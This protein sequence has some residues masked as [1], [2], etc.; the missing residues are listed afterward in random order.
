MAFRATANS[1]R[2]GLAKGSYKQANQD[3]MGFADALSAGLVRSDQAKM[4]EDM[5]IRREKRAEARRVKA[6]A[7]AA[8]K[9]QKKQATL[10][11]LFLGTQSDDVKN[12]PTAKSQVMTLI[13]EGGISSLSSLTDYMDKNATFT[14]PTTEMKP[15][16]AMETAPPFRIEGKLE[17]SGYT[18]LDAKR[19]AENYPNSVAGRTSKQMIDSGLNPQQVGEDLGEEEITVDTGFSFGPKITPIDTSKLREDNWYGTYQQLIQKGDTANALLVDEWAKSTGN[20]FVAAGI[21]AND[22][23]G[24][25]PT[26]ITQMSLNAGEEGK[27]ALEPYITAAEEAEAAGKVDFWTDLEAMANVKEPTLLL[28]LTKHPEGSEAHTVISAQILMNEAVKNSQNLGVAAQALDKDEAFYNTAIQ[29]YAALAAKSNIPEM[30]RKRNAENLI[31]LNVMSILSRDQRLNNEAVALQN[32]PMKQLSAKAFMVEGGFGFIDPNTGKIKMPTTAQI[33]KYEKD[34]KEAT[35]VAAKPD[36]FGQAESLAKLDLSVLQVMKNLGTLDDTQL[37]LIDSAIATKTGQETVEAN[38]DALNF[39]GIK[40]TDGLNLKVANA[41]WNAFKNPDG[42][43]NQDAVNK[44]SR[45]RATIEGIESRPEEADKFTTAYAAAF[46]DFISRP[47]TEALSGEDLVTAMADFERNWKDTSAKT[48]AE[49]IPKEVVLNDTTIVGMIVKAKEQIRSQN[50]DEQA[51]GNA[52]I[53]NKLPDILNA[54]ITLQGLSAE[55]AIQLL[56]SAGIPRETATLIQGKALSIKTDAVTKEPIAVNIANLPE[57]RSG[58][59]PT[60]PPVVEALSARNAAMSTPQ[61][62]SVLEMSPEDIASSDAVLQGGHK[63]LIRKLGFNPSF[64]TGNSG[65]FG[66]IAN[67]GSSLLG[68]TIFKDVAKGV[69]YMN[70]LNNTTA[71]IMS[72]SVEGSR[73]SVYNKQQLMKILPEAAKLGTTDYQAKTAIDRTVDTLQ[74]EL[75]I[76]YNIV[77]DPEGKTNPTQKAEAYAKSLQMDTVLNG[78]K[79]VQLAFDQAIKN[80]DLKDYEIVNKTINSETNSAAKPTFTAEQLRAEKARREALKGGN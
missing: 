18:S 35:T 9:K 37:A 11:T 33:T 52:F 64:S 1:V 62:T 57:N 61:I 7:D 17:G 14:P 13:Q 74:K 25:S 59:R 36:T 66:N 26:E 53:T 73:D 30:L 2:S 70:A 65:F 55:A 10:A 21:T 38:A 54:K 6:A 28:E 40:S 78:Y 29:R 77:D 79:A 67:T 60:D 71:R 12:S 34:F 45:V 20:N 42:T 72:V 63:S 5:E 19:L 39:D 48:E 16:S 76:L 80:Y 51:V 56:I 24:K 46:S 27:K 32:L 47:E 75:N 44:L 58:I 8:E 49:P 41:G 15:V 31:N 3:F 4:K 23:Q 69:D 22:L 50:A 43:V 68:F